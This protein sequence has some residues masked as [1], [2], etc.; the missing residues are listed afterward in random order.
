MAIYA[1]AQR[2]CGRLP[3]LW[4]GTPRVMEALIE[5]ELLSIDLNKFGHCDKRWGRGS[6]S[7]AE[8]S[9]KTEY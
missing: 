9:L 1:S 8:R 7:F 3:A 5:L 2:A 6:D 4:P